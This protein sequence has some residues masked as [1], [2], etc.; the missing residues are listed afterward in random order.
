WRWTIAD[1]TSNTGS[2][3]WTVPTSLA[4]GTGYFV[5]IS[6]VS[7]PSVT[8]DSE[9]FSIVSNTTASNR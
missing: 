6:S 9:H 2:Y 3:N 8:G 1:N 4:P 5:R 7:D